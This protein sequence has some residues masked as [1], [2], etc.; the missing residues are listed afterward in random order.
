MP[1]YPSQDEIKEL[2]DYDSETGVLTWRPRPETSGVLRH[3]NKRY[4]GKPAG[5]SD[6]YNGY[7]TVLI[8]KKKYPIHRI[9]WIY[10]NGPTSA[11]VVDHINGMRTDNRIA[12][13]REATKMENNRHRSRKKDR[14]YYFNKNAKLW[15]VRICTDYNK[16]H[17]GYYPDENTAREAYL[18]AKQIHHGQFSGY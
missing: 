14:G 5:G 12:N 18:K 3:W 15:H 11:E 13:L 2:F 9:I 7:I 16:V 10:C 17:V 1:V 6:G 8:H 4:A